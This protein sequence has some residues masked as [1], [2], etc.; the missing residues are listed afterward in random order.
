MKVLKKLLIISTVVLNISPFLFLGEVR[1]V[2]AIPSVKAEYPAQ[3][4]KEI[5]KNIE[6]GVKLS[7]DETLIYKGK[8][9]VE[10][11]YTIFYRKDGS[12]KIPQSLRNVKN[13]SIAGS[14]GQAVAI[15][16][17]IDGDVN[18]ALEELN[19]D[20]NVIAVSQVVRR[21]ISAVPTPNDPL[22]PPSN[23]FSSSYQWYLSQSGS[24]NYGIDVMRAWQHLDTQG[25]SWG[26]DST[27]KV[28]VID[29]GLAYETTTKY[30]YTGG[31]WGFA[32]ASDL[33]DNLSVN[34]GETADDGL[35]NDANGGI[36]DTFMAGSNTLYC[37]DANG[38]GQCE[39]PSERTKSYADDVNGLNLIDFYNYWT[40]LV[41]SI[42]SSSNC[43]NAP[44]TSYKCVAQRLC[45]TVNDSGSNHFGCDIS[46]MGHPND[47]M[48]HGTA[49]TSIIAGLASNSTAGIGIAPNV[50]ILPINIFGYV[51]DTNSGQWIAGSKP[52]MP[53]LISGSSEV[54][55]RAIEYA[56]SQGVNIINMSFG[57]QSPDPFEQLAMER[58]YEEDNVLLVAASGNRNSSSIDYP[59]GYGSVIA[60]GSSSKNGTRASYSSYG[61]GLELV[62]PVSS[63]VPVQS[64]TCYF[65]SNSYD[66]PC[67][68]TNSRPNSP[69]QFTQ[70][71]TG[72]TAGTSFAAPQ[73][74]AVAAL[75]W[76]LNPTWSNEQIRYVLRMSATNTSGGAYS[77]AT[78]YGIL[79]AYNAVRATDASSHDLTQT[80][81]L[82]QT[83][84]G[85]ANQLYDRTSDDHGQT[86][87]AWRLTNVGVY[88]QPTLVYDTV[89][90]RLVQARRDGS[91]RL[92][93]RNSADYG[94]TWSG[95]TQLGRTLSPVSLVNAN[96]RIVLAIRGTD[97]G[98]YTKSSTNGGVSWSGWQK[99]GSTPGLVSMIYD[100]NTDR[101]IQG[102]RGGD[103]GVYTRYSTDKGTTWS[104]WVRS[105]STP[106]NLSFVLAGSRVIMYV[107][108]GNNAIFSRYTTNGGQSWSSWSSNSSTY[109]DIEAVYTGSRIIQSVRD[110]GNN[111]LTRYSTNLGGSWSSWV[112]SGQTKQNIKMIYDG[113]Y[114]RVIATVIGLDG[115]IWT[116]FSDNGGTTWSLWSRSGTTPNAPDI[117]FFETSNW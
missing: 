81:R 44:Y 87:S 61:T 26:G 90:S 5:A 84:R 104:S 63:G 41:S 75:M 52:G 80:G 23:S 68:G 34:A 28:A 65:A 1:A 78:G 54:V 33:A 117:A 85:M 64:Y 17:T 83:V 76:T 99:N 56:V 79:N 35:D 69:S 72:L 18:K 67:L 113:Q 112:R 3:K 77:S 115:G 74:S 15:P 97:S 37:L 38:N 20:P 45:E 25:K 100:S 73:V 48:G 4:V 91:N 31:S 92:Y 19:K 116:R 111:I 12:S 51:Y 95:W 88:T 94:V 71:T 22:F 82:Y 7:L 11:R 10:G 42:S 59:A 14:Y 86:W 50:T 107:R 43:S 58:A 30:A 8:D 13:A 66:N 24:G 16:A 103:S 114:T 36:D 40:P 39:S 93:V 57:G 53:S 46:E 70:F 2:K 55:A 29:T 110:S 32:P 60:V 96:G 21:D 101:V 89:N 47:M 98:I 105:G 102:V 106:G 62:A 49:V 108:G 9:V 6:N 27:I 109:S